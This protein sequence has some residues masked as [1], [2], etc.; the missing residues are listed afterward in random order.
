M[1]HRP[2]CLY[3]KPPPPLR[4][5]VTSTFVSASQTTSTTEGSCHV[6]LC[7]CITN[8]LH[9]CGVMSRRPLCL[10]H[11]PPPPLRGR[12]TSTFVSASQTTSTTEGSCHV[13]L[14]VC[15]TNHLHHCGV[16]SRRPLCLHHKPPPP[17]RGRH[18]TSTFV[19]A[20]QTTS[21][22]AGSCHVDL[23]VCITNH[24]HHCGVVSRRPLCLH[25]KPPP[26]L[27]GRVTST[28]VSASQTTSTIAGS[29]HVDLCVCITN[30]LHH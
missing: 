28:F 5:R 6:D 2:L 15:I 14:C 22:T 29:C 27:R 13:D 12:V 25:H 16:V 8:H 24:L 10:H 17:L 20:S 7:V 23:C 4:G 3:H 30:H 18:V 11:K 1:S 9:H 19:S 21:T 26:P